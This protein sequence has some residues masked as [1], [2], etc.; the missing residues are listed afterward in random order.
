MRTLKTNRIVTWPTEHIIEIER[1]QLVRIV[2][3]ICTDSDCRFPQLT[4]RVLLHLMAMVDA[5]N[6]VHVSAKQLAHTLGVHYNTVT[7]CLKYLRRIGV[8]QLEQKN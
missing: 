8:V 2:E 7:K 3:L 4:L 6:R 5:Q 1:R